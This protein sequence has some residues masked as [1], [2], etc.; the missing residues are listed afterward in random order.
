MACGTVGALGQATMGPN[1]K[2]RAFVQEI[3]GWGKANHID[4]RSARARVHSPMYVAKFTYVCG[5]IY[6]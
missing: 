6:P 1:A 5:K 2:A 4:F 3:K